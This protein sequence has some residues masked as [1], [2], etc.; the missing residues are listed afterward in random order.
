MFERLSGAVQSGASNVIA[1]AQA[2][3]TALLAN[4]MSAQRLYT[5]DGSAALG[6]LM[7]ERFSAVDTI[8]E[9]YQLSLS[10]LSLNAHIALQSLL[11]Q[12]L[13]LHT[14][15][16]DGNRTQRSGLIFNAVQ[17]QSD[18]GLARYQLTVQPWIAMLRHGSHSRV[19]QD[20]SITQIIDDVL[21]A[22]AYRTHAAWQ[23]GETAGD[24]STEDLQAFLAQ[25]PNAGVRSYCVQYRETDLNFV[26]RLLAQ[27]GL[28]WRVEESDKA[29]SG[30]QI[31]FFADSSRWPQNTTSQAKLGGQGIRFHRGAA[32]EQQ[33]A[34][35]SFGGLRQ[36]NPASTALLQW[37][38]QAK[39][40]IAA[41]AP[42]AH[43]FGSQA[44]EDMAP[45][46][47][48][49]ELH[50]AS[51]DTGTCTTAQ[52]QH[53][54]TCQQQAFEARNKTWVARSTVR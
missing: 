15:L 43:N 23:W 18:G 42:T 21:G 48:H 33:D 40:A 39:R 53:R 37:D 31:V 50:G 38:Y 9:P 16:S 19:W 25:G 6:E 34:I 28:G 32:V 22:A 3:L 26:Q 36:L 41:E 11:G 4:W 35:Q 54:A 7:V 1:A 30:H 10:T 52:A 20:K 51:A 17:G 14:T 44:I 12:R 2:Q 5:V 49:Y 29:P 45:W 24:G 27:E 13:T 47:Q 8:S 46:L